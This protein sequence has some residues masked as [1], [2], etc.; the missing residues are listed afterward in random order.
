MSSKIVYSLIISFCSLSA[1]AADTIHVTVKTKEKAVVAIGYSMD[2]KNAGGLGKSYSGKGLKNSTYVF[3]YRKN[4]L[5]GAD[6]K[7]G[8]LVL[9][10]DSEITLVAKGDSCE[11]VVIN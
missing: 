2:G 10:K 9:N 7:C 5:G 1:F 8:A 11:T 4:S 6:I 3:G